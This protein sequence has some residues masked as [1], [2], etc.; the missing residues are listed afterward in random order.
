M[1]RLSFASASTPAPGGGTVTERGLVR[2]CRKGAPK[3][4]TRATSMSAG[5]MYMSMS[6]SIIATKYDDTRTPDTN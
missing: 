5:T 3:M 4:L 2:V 6:H 1:G